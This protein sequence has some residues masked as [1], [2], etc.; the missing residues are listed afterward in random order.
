MRLPSAL[1]VLPALLV[2]CG[3]ASAVSPLSALISDE[4]LRV[5]DAAFGASL[6]GAFKLRLEVGSEAAS[7]A[8][9]S[10]GNFTVQTESGK[11]VGVDVLDVQPDSLFPVS[12]AKGESK[13]LELTFS[14]GSVDR[15]KVCAGPLRIV[16]SVMDSAKGDTVSVRSALIT[17]DCS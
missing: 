3:S 10:I 1:W 4:S 12:I 5:S 7:S 8:N 14:E 6:S 15:A 2:G 9:V 13:E 11:S 17:P 16:G